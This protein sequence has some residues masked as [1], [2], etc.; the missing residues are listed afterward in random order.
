[1]KSMKY[2]F[3]IE[4]DAADDASAADVKA[5][6]TRAAENFVQAMVPVGKAALVKVVSGQ[7]YTYVSHDDGGRR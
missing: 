2:A 1:V 4:L 5:M 7:L 6:G 3:V